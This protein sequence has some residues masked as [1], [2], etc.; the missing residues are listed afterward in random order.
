MYSGLGLESIQD[1]CWYRKLCVFYKILTNLSPKYFR[2]II[3]STTR[4]DS[5]RN[6]NNIPLVRVST[7]NGMFKR[8]IW[9]KLTKFTFLKI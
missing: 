4:R 7:S 6:A 1:R 8:E 3:P 2:D 9:D 5:S